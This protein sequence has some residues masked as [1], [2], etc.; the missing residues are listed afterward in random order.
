MKNVL[1]FS[2]SPRSQ[3]NS[4]VMLNNFLKGAS[5]NTENIVIVNPYK[6][7]INY[8]TGC[9]RCN[10]LKECSI[11]NDDWKELSEKILAADILVFAAPV[12]FHHLPAP[13]KNI[14]DRFRSFVNVQITEKG[15]DHTPW[16]KWNKDFVVILSMGSSD[17]VDA[18]PIIDLFKY[19]TEILGSKNRLHIIKGTRL[20][21]SRQVERSKEE[22][23]I[24]YPKLNLP[25][26]LVESDYEKNQ[27]LLLDCADL[28]RDLSIK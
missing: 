9:L 27:Q 23:E 11:R 3:G 7:K 8:C 2:G 6:A 13:L 25:L 28:G 10:M 15:I 1:A 21:I 14:V 22:L 24:L 4:V 12:Y 26:H 20:A 18:E 17:D 5:E 19:M 16:K